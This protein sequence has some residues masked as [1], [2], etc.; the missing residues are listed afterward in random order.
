M[1][2]GAAAH[3]NINKFPWDHGSDLFLAKPKLLGNIKNVTKT[4]NKDHLL[5]AYNHLFESLSPDLGH[6][7]AHEQVKNVKLNDNKIKETKSEQTLDEGPPKYTKF[8]SLQ[9]RVIFD[10]NIKTSSKKK[11][12]AKPLR[13]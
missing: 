1:H 2:R 11:E 9:D 7:L 5:T 4:S 12:N 3:E 10:T 8:G 13:F 6:A